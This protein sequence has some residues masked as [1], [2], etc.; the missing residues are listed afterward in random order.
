MLLQVT[1]AVGGQGL[2]WELSKEV[3]WKLLWAPC[4]LSATPLPFPQD[5]CHLNSNPSLTL[6]PAL[7]SS[8]N[9]VP[10]VGE[11]SGPGKNVSVAELGV[12][13][14]WGVRDHVS[15]SLCL[16]VCC[17]ALCIFLCTVSVPVLWSACPA[18]LGLLQVLFPVLSPAL[19]PGVCFTENGGT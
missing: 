12:R 11:C 9:D 18:L 5:Y 17:F 14:Q 3:L 7:Q 1:I 6:F 16:A 2:L 8:G 19:F 10:R 13:G 15:L 4:P